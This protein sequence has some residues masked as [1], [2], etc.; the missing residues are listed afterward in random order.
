LK[1]EK[2]L[3]LVYPAGREAMNRDADFN[4]LLSYIELNN[5][6]YEV[7]NLNLKTTVSHNFNTTTKNVL[8]YFYVPDITLLPKIR[9]SLSILKQDKQPVIVGG[10]PALT[11]NA[12][13]ILSFFEDINVI[14][15][16]PESERVLLNLLNNI[17][18]K[19]KWENVKGITYRRTV[20]KKIIHTVDLPLSSN[21]DHLC[22]HGTRY[23]NGPYNGWYH[24][25]TSR[26]CN[27]DCQ[28]CGFQIPYKLDYGSETN[29]WRQKSETKIVDELEEIMSKGV[30][31]FA[32]NCNQFFKP[33]NGLDKSKEKIAE[34]ILKRKLKLKFRFSAKPTEIKKNFKILPLL[35][36]AG[37]AKIDVSI[38]S[39]IERFHKMYKTGTNVKTNI[40]VL[41]YLYDN[42]FDFDIGFIFYD[43]YLTVKEIKENMAFLEK[44]GKF[45]AR[46]KKPYAFFLDSRILNRVLVLRYGMPVIRQL[47]NDNLIAEYPGFSKH[48]AAKFLD[49]QVMYIYSVYRMVIETIIP[50]VRA[51]FY[52]KCLIERHGFINFFPLKLLEEIVSTVID[53]KFRELKDYVLYVE[54]FVK[55]VFRPYIERIFSDFKE[56]ENED[57][58]LWFGTKI[59]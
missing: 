9:Y 39:G 59:I 26:G 34:E 8:Y 32:F 12:G 35:K 4:A 11:I 55:K 3:I 50:K 44:A 43:P 56:Y 51:F 53:N 47:R 28:Y 13:E 41:E 54:A 48:P 14:V 23:N 52:N 17:R 18:D 24:I 42:E 10:D 2:K 49:R 22:G 15:R 19:E 16:E 1:Q 29:V 58:K 36:K 27:Y 46:Q 20:D 5:T 21:L 31:K 6:D 38:D 37:L 30:Q 40:E 33:G 25:I 7:R 45:F 57:I